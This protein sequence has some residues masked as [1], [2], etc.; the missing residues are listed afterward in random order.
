MKNRLDKKAIEGFISKY[1][2][3]LICVGAGFA[4]FAIVT[5][6]QVGKAEEV[7]SIQRAGYSGSRTEHLYVEGLEE[8]PVSMDISV[9]PRRY[10]DDEVYDAMES[11]LPEA[12]NMARGKNKSMDE[13]YYDL[14]LRESV[15]DYGF[16]LSWTPRDQDI[17]RFD[18]TVL[19]EELKEPV[20]TELR[21]T[22]SNDQAVTDHAVPVTVMPRQYTDTEVRRKALTGKVAEADGKAA[23]E[24]AVTL[25]DTY[26]GRRLIYRS[27]KDTNYSFLWILGIVFAI[28][29]LL[30]DKENEKKADIIRLKQMQIDYPEIVSKLMVF[31]GAGM[32]VRMAWNAIAADY[33]QSRERMP[34]EHEER[35]AYIELC[36]T[37]SRIRTGTPEGVAYRQFGHEC[38]SKQYMKLASLLEQN[39]KTGVANM[40]ALLQTEMI[41]AWAE[42]KNL[43]LRQG[44]EAST[45]LMLPLMMMLVI[46]MVIIMIPA[47]MNM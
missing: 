39:R 9:Q 19:N 5:V 10:R 31:V 14:D 40:K 33:E 25:P 8:A 15:G 32:S 34:G 11:C 35:Y 17:I 24:A 38:R 43:A 12:V 16:L 2:L 46:V 1:R 47:L 37:D 4:L 3:Q 13:V 20:Q 26:Q 29:L 23:T 18:G 7:R 28:L 45:K 6:L 22:I 41:E 42:R 36:K 21:L 27:G 30:R 44:E